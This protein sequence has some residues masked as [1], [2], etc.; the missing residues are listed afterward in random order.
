MSSKYFTICYIEVQWRAD[1]WIR[2][3]KQ[4]VR[5]TNARTT[6][7]ESSSIA[8]S[9]TNFNKDIFIEKNVQISTI[10]QMTFPVVFLG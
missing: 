8:I 10:L 5:K 3:Y 4:T 2:I 1:H 6:C 7:V 9:I